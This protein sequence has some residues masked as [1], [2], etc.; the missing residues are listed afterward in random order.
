MKRVLVV[1]D[2]NFMRRKISKVL[3]DPLKLPVRLQMEKGV[4]KHIELRPDMVT[5]ISP[6]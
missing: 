2:A 1:D 4:K 5:W 6:C 3:K